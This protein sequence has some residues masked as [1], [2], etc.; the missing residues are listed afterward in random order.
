M[1]KKSLL[2][3]F[4]DYLAY[5]R[6]YSN[7]TLTAYLN[8]LKQAE[9]FWKNNGG[10]N[11]FKQVT[12]RDIEIYIASLASTGL[13]QAS[14]ARKLSS[15]KSFYKFLTRR[16]LVEVDPTQTVSIHRKSKKLPEFF[17]EPEIKKVLDS[18]SASDKL[19][20][21]NKAMFELFY[22][23][24]M[25]VSEVSNLTLEQID[26][27]VQ[28]ILVHGKGNKD[29]YVPFGD[30]AKACLLRY[31]NEAR[32]LFNPD[33]DNHYVFLDN[34][35]HQLTSRGIEYIMRKVFQKG[36]LSANVHPHELRHTFA[37]QMLNNGADLR[38][39]QE[40]LGHESLSTTQIYTHVTMERLQKDYEKFFPRN[41]G[42]D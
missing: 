16:N 14:Q 30:Y 20:V 4:K 34:R 13:S 12:S 27:D 15:L 42:K 9:D 1:T 23:T 2:E 25:R 36:G 19:T 35:G 39:V 8:D 22:A 21:R 29:R 11:G 3:Q 17:Y 18:L 5:E 32:R 7:L 37:T 6:G 31:L 10:F 41:K 33:D 24:G 38:S 40:L 28:M 26:F